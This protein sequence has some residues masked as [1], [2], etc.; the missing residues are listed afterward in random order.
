MVKSLAVLLLLG[1]GISSAYA[2]TE[3]SSKIEGYGVLD[4]N[5]LLSSQ[6]EG[7][8][9]LDTNGLQNS[10]TTGYVVLGVG[11]QLAKL[12]GY[13]VLDGTVPFASPRRL[14]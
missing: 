11:P 1:L 9:V 3:Q 13:A 5:G 14:F 4:T 10:K 8:G 2:Q 6:I 12:E 7:Y